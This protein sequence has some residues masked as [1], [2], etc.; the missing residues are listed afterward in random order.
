MLNLSGS[1]A[2]EADADL[3]LFAHRDEVTNPETALKGIIELIPAKFRHGTCNQ[4][5]Y[6][7]RR[8]DRMG[9]AFYSLTTEQAAELDNQNKT[10]EE[11]QRPAR[12]S[13]RKGE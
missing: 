11:T 4:T 12:Y 7:G 10:K 8:E 5:S 2:I 3:V 9:G 6:I 13:K 1:S